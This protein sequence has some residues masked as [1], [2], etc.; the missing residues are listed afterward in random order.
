[1]FLQQAV[2]AVQVSILQ[3]GLATRQLLR[4]A[5]VAVAVQLLAVLVVHRLAV[6]VEQQRETMQPLTRRLAVVVPMMVQAVTVVQVFC[7]FVG[8][9]KTWHILL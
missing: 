2:L 9:F 1:V 4:L 7:I 3:L 8:R 5:A 6:L